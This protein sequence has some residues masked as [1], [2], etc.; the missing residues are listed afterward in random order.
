MDDR[1]ERCLAAGVEA[2][3]EFVRGRPLDRA[4][5]VQGGWTEMRA[6]ELEIIYWDAWLAEFNKG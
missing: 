2:L 3:E 4:K 1:L 5:V 6:L